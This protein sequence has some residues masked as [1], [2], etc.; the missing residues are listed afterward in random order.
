MIQAWDFFHPTKHHP[1]PALEKEVQLGGILD[2]PR[3]VDVIHM[4]KPFEGRLVGGLEYLDYLF[5]YWE[6]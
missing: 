2:H 5:I 4:Y 6:S 3:E 1:I